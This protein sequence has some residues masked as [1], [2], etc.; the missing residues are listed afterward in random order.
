MK[1]ADVLYGAV[2]FWNGNSYGFVRPDR[3]QLHEGSRGYATLQEA[4]DEAALHHRLLKPARWR[5]QGKRI[6]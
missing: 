5:E 2:E 1:S 4:A 3:G 6:A